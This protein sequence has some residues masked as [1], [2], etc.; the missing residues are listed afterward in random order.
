MQ[1]K[2]RCVSTLLGTYAVVHL[3][4]LSALSIM[5]IISA[6][7]SNLTIS[8]LVKVLEMQFQKLD[9][10]NAAAEKDGR[11]RPL[12]RVLFLWMDNAST[13][14][15][16]NLFRLCAW[17]VFSG[18]FKKVRIGFLIVGHTHDVVDRM[19]SRI[20]TWL[21]R[22][23][24]LSIQD[25]VARLHEAFKTTGT[26][27]SDARSAELEEQPL[28]SSINDD[29]IEN[30]SDEDMTGPVHI[31]MYLAIGKQKVLKKRQATLERSNADDALP[32]V[33]AELT[34]CADWDGWLQPIALP[35]FNIT[36]FHQFKFTYNKVMNPL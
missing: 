1:T 4:L 6:A 3:F 16:E 19:C 5:M 18:T 10:F 29:V 2:H 27:I 21:K 25:Y 22:N 31:Q 33:A 36:P 35:L 8:G 28:T 13:N 12:P 24:L 15:N 17:L 23:N 32:L 14:K 20:S 9:E 30:E 11:K 7:D 26:P 34:E